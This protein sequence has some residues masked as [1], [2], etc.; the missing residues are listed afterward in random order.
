M[1]NDLKDGHDTN[2]C[3]KNL[4]ISD[5]SQICDSQYSYPYFQDSQLYN[6]YTPDQGIAIGRSH[7]IELSGNPPS[8][9]KDIGLRK[10]PDYEGYNCNY[11]YDR[12]DLIKMKVDDQRNVMG[13]FY[14]DLDITPSIVFTQ[15]AYMIP[16]MLDCYETR[17]SNQDSLTNSEKRK[18]NQVKTA[19][20]ILFL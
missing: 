2:L 14:S 7:F 1:N 11:D 5:L 8:S 19:C 3:H 16:S 9:T 18:R 12:Y 4:G 10:I 13:D 20:S 6:Y 15:P 17:N